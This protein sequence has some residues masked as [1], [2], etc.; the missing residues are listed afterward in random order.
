MGEKAENM[1]AFK[2]LSIVGGGCV[3]KGAFINFKEGKVEIAEESLMKL[4]EDVVL[5][6]PRNAVVKETFKEYSSTEEKS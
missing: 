2:Y 6:K 5:L 1:D 4:N 3:T